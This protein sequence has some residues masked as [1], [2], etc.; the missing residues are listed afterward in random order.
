[1]FWFCFHY[2]LIC[3]FRGFCTG[4]VMS[5]QRGEGVSDPPPAPSRPVELQSTLTNPSSHGLNQ[6]NLKQ[7]VSTLKISRVA[8]GSL[9]QLQG[10]H[11]IYEISDNCLTLISFNF[12]DRSSS[13]T[14][15]RTESEIKTDLQRKVLSYVH[16]S[17]FISSNSVMLSLFWYRKSNYLWRV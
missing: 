2:G 14:L 16:S 13:V 8:S 15:T 9:K 11:I 17:Q 6:C 4:L 5:E 10:K 3:V 1:M 7:P 12:T